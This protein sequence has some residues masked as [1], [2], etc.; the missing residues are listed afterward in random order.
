MANDLNIDLTGKYVILNDNFLFLKSEGFIIQGTG[1]PYQ[2]DSTG[3]VFKCRGGLGINPDIKSRHIFGTIISIN[4][5][6]DFTG[7]NYINRIA[8]SDEISEAKLRRNKKAF[9]KKK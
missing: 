2:S 5:I 1:R 8:T 7:H 6:L 9:N 3:R 4:H